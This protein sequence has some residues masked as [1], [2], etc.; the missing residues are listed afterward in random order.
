MG[1]FTKRD[2]RQLLAA[3]WRTFDELSPA[4]PRE[5]TLGARMNLTFACVT[6]SFHRAL[7]ACGTE[8]SYAT[9]LVGD[10]AWVVYRPW[11]T[12]PRLVSRLGAREPLARLRLATNLFRRFPFGPPSYVMRDVAAPDV[13]AFDV[14][15][16]PIA[17]YFSAHGD[18]DVCV[19]TWCNLDYALAEAWGGRLVRPRTLAGGASRCDFRWRSATTPAPDVVQR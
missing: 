1:R 2:V 13:V 18:A 6:L 12:V 4:L 14:L 11:G 19:G 5:V 16:C 3:T 8:R 9:E 7:L 10:A 15:R 17:E